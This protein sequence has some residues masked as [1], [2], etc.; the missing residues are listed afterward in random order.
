MS[1]KIAKARRAAERNAATPNHMHLLLVDAARQR[2]RAAAHKLK[3]EPKQRKRRAP[4][5]RTKGKIRQ[6][7]AILRGRPLIVERPI[8]ALWRK[9]YPHAG[10]SVP[11]EFAK[12]YLRWSKAEMDNNALRGY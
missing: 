2:S 9:M 3:E 8:R 1:H 7:T 4:G 11:T 6:A 10:P 5:T 12:R